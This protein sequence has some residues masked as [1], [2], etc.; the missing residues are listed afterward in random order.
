MNPIVFPPF[1][2][3]GD[4]VA[5]IAPSSPVEP[6]ALALGV[7]RLKGRYRVIV[8]DD[9][10]SRVG[11]FAGDDTRRKDELQSVIDDDDIRAVIAARGGFGAS[12]ILDRIDF[13]RLV[14][15]PKWVVG[16][17]DLT[18]L[19]CHLL[20]NF[21]VASIHGPMA[22]GFQHTEEGD[23]S[24]LFALLEGAVRPRFMELDGLVPGRAEGPL[25]GGNL[26]VLA[27]LVGTVRRDFLRGAILFLE[28]V[29]EKPYRL[30][31]C[32]TQLRRSG[33]LDDIAGIVLGEFTD[34]IANADGVDAVDGIR[35]FAMEAKVPTAA[36]YP[37][38]H[39]RRNAPFVQGCDVVLE[40][41]GSHAR[42]VTSR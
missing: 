15:S 16:C 17:S 3:P 24:A 28:D 1:L 19:A 6:H 20:A 7:E 41:V 25:I 30:D 13:H 18:A 14:R 32:L 38:A 29:G 21:S 22:A 37:A 8:R 23:V 33:M 27:H 39:G 36:G 2:S 5:V 31:R 26:T 34:C 35:A 11:Y 4:S 42:L 9:I 10:S 12:R 40:V